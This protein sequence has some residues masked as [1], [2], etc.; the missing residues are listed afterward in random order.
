MRSHAAC[1]T[2]YTTI[3]SAAAAR[4]TASSHD[5]REC[6]T[7]WPESDEKRCSS[8]FLPGIYCLPDEMHFSHTHRKRASHDIIASGRRTRCVLRW[9]INFY[10]LYLIA[11]A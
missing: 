8:S 7:L 9:F 6:A 4:F 3:Y 5:A 1:I 11:D 10:W 2:L